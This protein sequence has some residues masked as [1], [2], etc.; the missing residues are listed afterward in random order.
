MYVLMSKTSRLIDVKPLSQPMQ[1]YCQSLKKSQQNL[2]EIIDNSTMQDEFESVICKMGTIC[3][4]LHTLIEI[5]KHFAWQLWPTLR[6]ITVNL[7]VLLVLKG[8]S[9]VNTVVN[10]RTLHKGYSNKSSLC[11][12]QCDTIKL[13]KKGQAICNWLCEILTP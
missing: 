9:I 7:H 10:L 6:T 11:S 1:T 4:G 5:Y 13:S 8:K 12:R 3:L 2:N